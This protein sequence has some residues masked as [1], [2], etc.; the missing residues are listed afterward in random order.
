MPEILTFGFWVAI[1]IGVLF[2]GAYAYRVTG[3]T[4]SMN[5]ALLA[6]QMALAREQKLTDSVWFFASSAG[7]R[8]KTTP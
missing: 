7:V 1:V 2:L 8:T 3:E 6:T 5:E 4:H